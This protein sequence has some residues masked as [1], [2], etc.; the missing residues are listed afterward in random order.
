MTRVIYHQLS[1]TADVARVWELWTVPAE[2]EKWFAPIAHIDPIVGGRYELFF[3]PGNLPNKNTAGCHIVHMTPGQELTFTWKGPK[4]FS[5]LMNA[6]V[7]QTTVN[8]RFKQNHDG[9][10]CVKLFHKGFGDDTTWDYA[11]DWHEL[12]WA[13]VLNQ[14]QAAVERSEWLL[15]FSNMPQQKIPFP[16]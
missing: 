15:G 3:V 9:T 10:T 16:V 2:V 14:L 8:V 12:V 11:Y 1:I 13:G 4:Q 5:N 6:P 7:P